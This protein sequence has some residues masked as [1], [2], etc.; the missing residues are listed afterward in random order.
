M[1]G[2]IIDS[3][4]NYSDISFY[5]EIHEIKPANKNIL[6]LNPLV[7]KEIKTINN[8]LPFVSPTKK[9]FISLDSNY[10][11]FHNDSLGIILGYFNI[12]KDCTFILDI[13]NID[14]YEQS[15]FHNFFFKV[16][17]DLKVKYEIINLNNYDAIHA[18]NFF[19]VNS[20]P[21]GKINTPS[22]IFDFYKKY[23][24]NIDCI[25]YK[26]TFLSR[27]DNRLASSKQIEEY[28]KNIGFDIVFAEDFKNFED[29]INY[30]YQV[31]TLVSVTSSGLTNCIFMQENT[32]VIE[33]L[34][35]LKLDII[36]HNQ[37][38]IKNNTTQIHYVYMLNSFL[39][40]QTY[41]SI[42]NKNNNFYDI[43]DRFKKMGDI[44]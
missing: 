6:L 32:S 17:N 5:T 24:N 33:I 31:K 19:I 4:D 37:K 12:L 44:L 8:F 11:H 35:P 1:V 22:I 41:V 3:V 34:T 20:Y 16:L 30:F 25:P 39:K 9:I 40:N 23:I 29:Q 15:S 2:S 43:I 42:P 27:K 7:S 18:N 13:S 21:Y 38:I 26:K 10:S 14:N 28:F 36:S